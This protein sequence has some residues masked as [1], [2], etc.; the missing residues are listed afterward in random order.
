MTLRPRRVP[1]STAPST[2]ANSV[3]SPPRP[4]PAAGVE[5]G[6]ALAHDD[7]AGVDDLAAVPLDA[8]ALG[9]GVATV[10][11]GRGA[12]LVC[13]RLCLLL[14]RS[15]GRQALMS[16]TLTWVYFWR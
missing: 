8:E 1:N 13:H 4:T 12:L 15:G 7:L 14:L 6:A 2:S 3:S 10:L 16:V 11:G 9:V 5:V